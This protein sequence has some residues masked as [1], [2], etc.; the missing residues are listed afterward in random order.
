MDIQGLTPI[1]SLYEYTGYSVSLQVGKYLIWNGFIVGFILSAALL[2]LYYL[3][4]REGSYKDLAIYPVYV[5]F[6]FFL[7]WPVPVALTAP[8]AQT[9]GFLEETNPENGV[10]W[11]P[12][13][14]LSSGSGNLVGPDTLKVPRILAYVS[15]LVGALQKN[16]VSDICDEMHSA[17]YQ[18]KHIAAINSNTRIFNRSLREDL[19]VYLRC[20]YYPALTQDASQDHDPWKSVPLVGL[21][22]DDTLI[23]LYQQLNLY[24][25]E[26]HQAN[27]EPSTCVSLH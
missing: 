9:G 12:S 17:M 21:P 27:N 18:W 13:N 15:A 5:L 14:P 11:D 3:G 25:L 6:I 1:D 24:A 26:T 19:G 2:R 8:K 10:F 16:L 20:C 22:I 23:A 4:A 7:L